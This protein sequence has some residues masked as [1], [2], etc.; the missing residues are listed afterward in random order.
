MS[1]LRKQTLQYTVAAVAIAAIVMIASSFYLSPMTGQQGANSATLVIQLTD[2]P[3][4]P[5]G[6]SSLNLTYS[7]IG[8]LVGE[9]AG[10]G[11]V[12]T[13]SVTVA[14][15]ATVDLLKLQ[16]I[17]KTIAS[18][19]LPA[20]STVYSLSFTVTGVM[21]DVSG[22]K[23]PVTLATGGSTLTVTLS[24]PSVIEGT[25]IALLRL[26]PVVVSTPS[27]YQLIPSA[28]G[29]VRGESQG[30]K[31]HEGV[32]SEQQLTSQDKDELNQASGSAAASLKALSV[33][34]D[35]TTLTVEVKNSGNGPIDINAIGIHGSFTVVGQTC[36]SSDMWMSKYMG[37]S[38]ST[39]TTTSTSTT[40]CESQHTDELVFVPSGSSVSGTGCVSMTMNLVNGDHSDHGNDH[41]LT[42][43]SGQCVDLT[44]SGK[45]TF[46]E[47]SFV[48]VPNTA[49]GQVYGVHVVASEGANM[50]LSCTLPVSSTSCS[51]AHGQD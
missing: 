31:G 24:R 49:S 16:N 2:P 19:S 47:A 43:A 32:G 28:V 36:P 6:T 48:L 21:I 40:T 42:L 41:S 1:S 5:A 35:V 45:I 12:T 4:V 13:K 11:Q 25:N 51:V 7:S 33:S 15:S 29:A 22:T 50:E 18:A 23:S 10:G 27:G 34:S 20:G 26:N 38:S 14:G 39:T 44:F 8:M 17:S 9:P 3:V 37:D 30:D 46:G